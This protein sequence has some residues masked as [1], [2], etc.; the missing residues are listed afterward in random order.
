MYLSRI[1][2]RNWRAYVDAG[3]DFPAP[4]D[5]QNIILI[6]ARNGY[7]K[8]SLF[9]AIVFGLFGQDGLHVIGR[10][11]LS[12]NDETKLHAPYK[13]FMENVLHAGAAP[14]GQAS[15]SVILRFVDDSDHEIEIR[16]IWHFDDSGSYRPSDDEV[17][18]YEGLARNAI[19]PGNLRGSDRLNWYRAYI[20]ETFVPHYLSNFFLFDGEQ[21]SEFAEREMADQVR[22]GIEGLLGIPILKELAKDL[23]AYA[24]ARLPVSARLDTGAIEDLEKEIN[25]LNQKIEQ[26]SNIIQRMES[27]LSE[28]KK[29]R[30]ILTR[31]LMSLGSGSQAQMRELIEQINQYRK[32]FQKGCEDLE[33]LL[34][35]DIALALVGPTLREKLRQRLTSELVRL[36]WESGKNQG[37]ENLERFLVSVENGIK[38]IEPALSNYQQ[39]SVLKTTRSA[40]SR[41]WNPP[42]ENCAQDYLHVYM[43]EL[44]RG[45]VVDELNELMKLRASTI[46]QLL[47]SNVTNEREIN[48]LQK[49]IDRIEGLPP[50]VE[51]K[52]QRIHFLNDEVARLERKLGTDK[53][54]FMLY[55]KERTTRQQDL[56]RR[57]EALDQAQPAIRRSTRARNVANMVDTIVKRAV[58]GQ[59]GAIAKAM[60]DAYRSMVHKDLVE[61]IDIDENCKVGLL[62]RDGND[63]REHD[64]SAGEKQIFTQ[65]LIS[66]VIQVSR[67]NFPMVIDTPLGRLDI[68]HRKGILNHLTKRSHQIIL[69]S[70][71]TEVVGE[72]LHEITPHVQRKYL[73]EFEQIGEVGQSNVRKGYFGEEEVSL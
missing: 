23:R 53:A 44:D 67:R 29:E 8:T 2:L 1:T 52:R 54:Q 43:N 28:L 3:F 62:N 42:P 40:W 69:L 39:D 51:E 30:D 65:A 10:T 56:G 46:E 41:L 35:K 72:Y 7:G 22:V 63:L 73:I 4:N 66:A 71:D 12:G 64:L 68:Q 9:E 34:T 58:P 45:K 49:E 47:E 19:G 25:D 37:D 59:I 18:I 36:R 55:E 24:R 57:T 48:R 5:R 14:A 33:N 6:G 11:S 20:S 61:R 32:V 16:R 21:V 13:A 70:T 27:E 26:N 50:H 31:E 15:C 38:A 60:T 17:Y